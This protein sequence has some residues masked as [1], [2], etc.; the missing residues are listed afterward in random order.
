M[1]STPNWLLLWQDL[2]EAHARGREK[3]Q[4]N[5]HPDVW[6]ARARGYHKKVQRRWEQPDSSRDFMAADLAQH[7]ND[8]VL[9]IGA[10]TGA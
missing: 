2:V 8:T 9:D 3:A 1:E 5:P 4:E 7:P 6:R 10:G